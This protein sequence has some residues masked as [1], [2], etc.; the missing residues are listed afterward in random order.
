MDKVKKELLI[1]DLCARLPYGVKIS[2]NNKVEKLE[3][4]GVLDDV[5][6]YG[7]FLCSSIEEVKPYLFPLSSITEEQKKELHELWDFNMSAALD[8]AIYGDELK[9]GLHQLTAAKKV[10][11][12]CYENHFDIN[13][14]IIPIGLAIDATGLNI[15]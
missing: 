8:C 14:L 12:W 5:V 2:V 7:S 4:I 10:N 6:E 15:Y 9:S 11:E 13:G 3:G 1:K